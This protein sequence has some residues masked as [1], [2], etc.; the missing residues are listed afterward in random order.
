M[1]VGK[2]LRLQEFV[3]EQIKLIPDNETDSAWIYVQFIGH[4]VHG[5]L[6]VVA[7]AGPDLRSEGWCV[8]CSGPAAAWAS[9]GGVGFVKT[10]DDSP[11]SFTRAWP[12]IAAR[13][14]LISMLIAY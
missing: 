1:S 10:F 4:L 8:H 13:S 2:G 12:I 14:S 9:I 3:R 6:V 11:V 7:D 5:T